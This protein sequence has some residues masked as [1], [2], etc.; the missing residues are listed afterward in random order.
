MTDTKN[1][2]KNRRVPTRGTIQVFSEGTF[3]EG[4]VGDIS[5]GG[6]FLVVPERIPED[7]P[8]QV[9]LLLHETPG[10][11]EAEAMFRWSRDME[12]GKRRGFGVEFTDI[13]PDAQNILT[14]FIA[15]GGI[16]ED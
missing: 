3:T 5:L 16:E 1:R 15:S 7:R 12:K 8:L 11:I 13:G 10:P 9:Q 2:R 6:L 14:E 4:T